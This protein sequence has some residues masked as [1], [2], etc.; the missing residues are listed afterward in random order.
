MKYLEV[1]LNSDPYKIL[2]KFITEFVPDI[3]SA[4]RNSRKFEVNPDE[5]LSAD[6]L[7]VLFSQM[8][9]AMALTVN[10]CHLKYNCVPLVIKVEL[11]IR[12]DAFVWLRFV[13][14]NEAKEPI[15]KEKE[16]V[17]LVLPN[18]FDQIDAL[19]KEGYN[20]VMLYRRFFRPR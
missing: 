9:D 20:I 2:D 15:M 8:G 16:N 18:D 4:L 7:S 17:S 14:L 1:D 13:P 3:F 6:D 12:D 10:Y 5:P 11:K 19:Q